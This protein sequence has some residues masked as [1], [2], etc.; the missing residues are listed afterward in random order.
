MV[1]SQIAARF[2]SRRGQTAQ[3]S[4]DAQLRKLILF[5]ARLREIGGQNRVK[6]WFP[7]RDH[8]FAADHF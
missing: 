2:G 6:D 1:G 7:L 3:I 8:I 4:K 5:G